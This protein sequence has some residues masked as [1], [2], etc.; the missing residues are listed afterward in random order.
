M[1]A[2]LVAKTKGIG[3][4]I[5]KDSIILGMMV[6]KNIKRLFRNSWL[7]VIWTVLNPLLNM[8]VMVFVFSSFLTGR[9]T[10]PPMCFRAI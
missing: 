6:K 3:E 4:Q 2:K 8:L 10:S 9:W 7:G 1:V 5:R